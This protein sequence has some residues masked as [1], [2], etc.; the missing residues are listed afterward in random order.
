MHIRMERAFSY[1]V[2]DQPGVFRTLPA[3]W[4]GEVDDDIGAA[5]VKDGAAVDTEQKK[6]KPAKA[7]SDK[8]IVDGLSE[9]E[10]AD[11]DKLDAAGKAKFIADKKSADNG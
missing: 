8:E 9:A 3:G 4:V 5:A 11:F 1:D 6:A 2:K 10:K 7:P